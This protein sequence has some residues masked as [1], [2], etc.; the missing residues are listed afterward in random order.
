MRFRILLTLALAALTSVAGAVIPPEVQTQ[1][2]EFYHKD[3]DH[4]FITTDPKEI[5]D[6]DTGVHAGWVRTGFKFPSV[7]VGSTHAATNPVCR[8]YGRPEAKIDSHFYSSKVSECDDVKLKFPEAWQFE[9]DEVFR[10]FAVDP[11]TG[12]CPADTTP[13][14]RLWNQRPDVNHRYTDQDFEFAVMVE[15]GYKAEGDGNPAQPV[16]FCVPA[17]G[18]TVPPAPAGSPVCTIAAS[19]GAPALGSILTL[20]ATCSETPTAYLWVGCTS[21]T[22]TCTTS[23][24]VAGPAK[25]TVAATNDKGM[26]APISMSVAWGGVGGGGPF[27][28]C[29]V[30]ATNKTPTAGTPITLQATCTLS[31]TRYNWFECGYLLTNACNAI[32]S[33]SATSSTCTVTSPNAVARRYGATGTNA[34]G[35]GVIEASKTVEVSWQGG[36]G[37]PPPPPT[38]QTPVCSPSSSNP[39]PTVGQTIT[40]NANCTGSPTSYTWTA[41]PTSNC[42]N[43]ASCQDTKTTTGPQTYFVSGTNSFGTGSVGAVQVNWSAPAVPVCTISPSNST[44]LAGSTITITAACTGGPTTFSWTGCTSTTSTCQ[45]TVSVPG[46]KQYTM[47]AANPSGT[48]APATTLVNWQPPPTAAPSCTLASSNPTPFVGQTITLTATCTQA[49]TS[50]VWTNCAA[51]SS[52]ST[53]QTTSTTTGPQNYSVT[54]SNVQFGAG[55]PALTTVNWQQA[56]GGQDFCG[57][58]QNVVRLSKGWGDNSPIY[59]YTAGNFAANGVVVVSFVAGAG[60]SYRNAGSTQVAE[61]NG[62]PTFRQINLSKSSCDF[63]SVDPTGASGPFTMAQNSLSPQVFW[64]VGAPPV[65][66]V[67]GQTY[68][69]NI[70]NWSDLI[71]GTC[72]T[73]SCNAIIQFNWPYN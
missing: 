32:T 34:T 71:G 59:T 8:F 61:Y 46:A 64:N 54:A 41:P 67:P 43:T 63:R 5:S 58:Y 4:Y 73:A 22:N 53:C 26:G 70:R 11:E 23:R 62:P 50:Y 44:P 33:C 35:T 55:A 17:G 65:S 21:T 52:S 56:I 6:L 14:Y 72:Q 36:S 39:N 7:K 15:K 47:V 38:V 16:A 49:P 25:Y 12:R 20:T 68:Y 13:V 48:G 19:S 9:A 51:G 1:V 24:S 27:P 10:A 3:L 57:S 29:T 18:S 30:T 60:P 31:P 69:V 66:L 37:G 40:L 28:S 42:S 2:V 45:D